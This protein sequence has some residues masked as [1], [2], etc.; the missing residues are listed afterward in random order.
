[1][2]PAWF[3][4]SFDHPLLS[5]LFAAA[6]DPPAHLSDILHVDLTNPPTAPRFVRDELHTHVPA[7]VLTRIATFSKA[8]SRCTALAVRRRLMKPSV[9]RTAHFRADANESASSESNG[10]HQW[11]PSSRTTTLYEMK[12]V[13]ANT[14]P[15]GFILFDTASL[16]IS[17]GCPLVTAHFRRF[18]TRKVLFRHAKW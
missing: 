3:P 4:S 9:V 2:S 13:T 6:S 17:S 18:T 10:D 12:R 15:E 1:M 8:A 11:G 5:E 14:L 16:M 7:R